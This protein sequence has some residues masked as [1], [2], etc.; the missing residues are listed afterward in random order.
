MVGV[1]DMCPAMGETTCDVGM[2]SPAIGSRSRPPAMPPG[3]AVRPRRLVPGTA[4][5]DDFERQE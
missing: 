1:P 5:A 3:R 4:A 2:V